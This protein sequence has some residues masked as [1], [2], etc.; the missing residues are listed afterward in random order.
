MNLLK[1]QR[2][3]TQPKLTGI[4]ALTKTAAVQLSR[5]SFFRR[6]LVGGGALFGMNMFEVRS[7]MA[8]EG[9]V[10]CFGPCGECISGSSCCSEDGGTCRNRQCRCED[11]CSNCRPECFRIKIEVCNGGNWSSSCLGCGLG[12]CN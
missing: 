2:V 11:G 4:D 8:Q 1:R 5:R 3:N 6:V 9:C 7:V 10:E 12:A